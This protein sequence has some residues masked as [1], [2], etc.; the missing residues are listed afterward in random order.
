MDVLWK[1]VGFKQSFSI[2]AGQSSSAS[3]SCIP[4]SLYSRWVN[5]SASPEVLSS[6]NWGTSPS[7]VNWDQSEQHQAFFWHHCAAPER[8]YCQPQHGDGSCKCSAVRAAFLTSPE[9]HLRRNK[10]PVHVEREVTVHTGAQYRAVRSRWGRMGT[11][12]R[13]KPHHASAA[14]RGC[15]PTAKDHVFLRGAGQ[16][17]VQALLWGLWPL[18]S[19]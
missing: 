8:F 5:G 16:E 19:P 15:C 17:H 6:L 11:H 4:G 13:K 18:Q 12:N 10:T 1:E 14:L 3:C 7:C 2:P 9:L